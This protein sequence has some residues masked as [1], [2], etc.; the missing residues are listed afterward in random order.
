MNM[1]FMKTAEDNKKERLNNEAKSLVEQIQQDKDEGSDGEAG[2]L[3]GGSGK[4][5]G[6]LGSKFG[7]KKATKAQ[8][9]DT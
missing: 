4:F 7:G 8:V 9:I 3:F 5:G 1:K 2:G 6:G